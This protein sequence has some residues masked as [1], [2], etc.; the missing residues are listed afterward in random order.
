MLVFKKWLMTLPI[1]CLFEVMINTVIHVF[2]QLNL[3][4]IHNGQKCGSAG[5][6]R[7]RWVGASSRGSVGLPDLKVHMNQQSQGA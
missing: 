4:Y 2:T 5:G 7:G 6:L 3:S 1:V